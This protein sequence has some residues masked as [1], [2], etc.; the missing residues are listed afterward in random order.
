VFG[1]KKIRYRYTWK[2]QADITAYELAQMV[3]LFADTSRTTTEDV[4]A[5]PGNLLRHWT[6][7]EVVK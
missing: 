1:K 6:V 2:P 7:E 5:L 3:H 4:A